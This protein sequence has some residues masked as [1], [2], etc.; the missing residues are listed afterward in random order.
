MTSEAPTVTFTKTR[1]GGD[2]SLLLPLWVAWAYQQLPASWTVAGAVMILIGLAL[3]YRK[4][5][6][7]PD[8]GA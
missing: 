4:K 8:M 5:A 6:P 2:R 1:P 3:R 7:D